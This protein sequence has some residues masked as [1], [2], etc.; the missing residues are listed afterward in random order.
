[1][2][3]FARMWGWSDVVFLDMPIRRRKY[4]LPILYEQIKKA[5]KLFG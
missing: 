5:P 2:G 1:M 3:A 4:L